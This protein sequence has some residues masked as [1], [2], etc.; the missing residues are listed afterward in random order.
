LNGLIKEKLY[1]IYSYLGFDIRERKKDVYAMIKELRNNRRKKTHN[2][3]YLA[4]KKNLKKELY[5]HIKKLLR[6]VGEEEN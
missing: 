1:D 2:N 4:E 6:R 3:R 5:L